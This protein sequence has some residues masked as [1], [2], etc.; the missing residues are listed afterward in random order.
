MCSFSV[1][2]VIVLFHLTPSPPAHAS[3]S[4]KLQT[5]SVTTTGTVHGDKT[6]EFIGTV[7]S[8]NFIVSAGKAVGSAA[9]NLVDLIKRY[10][11][12]THNYTDDGSQR[13]TQAQNDA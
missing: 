4:V 12:H 11:G 2:P 5:P 6:A 1:F 10:T 7:T 13:V 8:P 9:K 3:S